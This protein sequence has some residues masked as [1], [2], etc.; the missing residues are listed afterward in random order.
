MR[1]RKAEDK[2]AEIPLGRQ[3][4]NSA[5]EQTS[6]N[7]TLMIVGERC[8]KLELPPQKLGILH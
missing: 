4:R 6:E 8:Y 2:E 3:P 5:K 7:D 1:I